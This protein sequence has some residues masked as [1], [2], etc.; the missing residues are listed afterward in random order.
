MDKIIAEKTTFDVAP[1]HPSVS[2]ILH[3]VLPVQYFSSY[4]HPRLMICFPSS[5]VKKFIDISNELRAK[6]K[7]GK[8]Y[9]VK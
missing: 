7:E 5:S 8:Y 3:P 1:L 6:K 4:V 9:Y 2:Q